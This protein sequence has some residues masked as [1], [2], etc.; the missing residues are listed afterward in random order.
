[1]V[2]NCARVL[3]LLKELWSNHDGHSLR[4]LNLESVLQSQKS[5]VTDQTLKT[6]VSVLV[7]LFFLLSEQLHFTV[8]PT[9]C[10]YVL[11]LNCK[12]VQCEAIRNTLCGVGV[13]S[14]FIYMHT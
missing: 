3:N 5:S 14:S 13:R 12:R 2:K 8:C 10:L 9:V 4:C 6:K 1:M 7:H 11:T